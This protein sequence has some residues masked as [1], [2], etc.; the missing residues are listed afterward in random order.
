MIGGSQGVQCG[1]RAYPSI[2]SVAV[3]NMTKCNLRR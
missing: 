3:I 1:L 2:L